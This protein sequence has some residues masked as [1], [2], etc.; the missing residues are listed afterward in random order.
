MD[1]LTQPR[2]VGIGDI[3]VD[4]GMIGV[5]WS[6]TASM[7]SPLPSGPMIQVMD[8]TVKIWPGEEKAMELGK[9]TIWL[10]IESTS[11][12]PTWRATIDEI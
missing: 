2:G 5:G 3:V 11:T 10:A 8:P 1:L 6:C 4:V 12:P 7:I 9:V